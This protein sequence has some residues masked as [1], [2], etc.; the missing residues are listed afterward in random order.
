M[1]NKFFILKCFY[2][3]LL[4]WKCK[5]IKCFCCLFWKKEILKCR[6]ETLAVTEIQFENVKFE[7]ADLKNE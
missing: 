5:N 6:N 7:K 1:L 3:K 2:F 4:N